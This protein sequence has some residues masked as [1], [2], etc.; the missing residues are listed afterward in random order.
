MLYE[1]WDRYR[2]VLIILGAALFIGISYL[3]YQSE[4]TEAVPRL[5]LEKPAY[6][7]EKEQLDE[8]KEQPK[9]GQVEENPATVY[10]D[11]KGSVKHPGLYRFS[12]NE[13]IFDAI[14]KAGGPLPEADLNQVNLAEPLT[15]GSAVRIPKKGEQRSGIACP[16]AGSSA[17][18]PMSGK[19]MAEPGKVNINT[20]AL[21]DLVTLPGIGEARAQAIIAYRTKNGPFRSPEDLKKVTGIG[22]KMYERMKD[23]I[24]VH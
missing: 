12:A 14:A 2:S 5:P 13:R 8:R 17:P 10:V 1:W 19:Q 18:P 4:S 24:T 20:A 6:A 21:Q 16:C 9:P 7:L 22:E 15:D 23:K 3:L 11:V